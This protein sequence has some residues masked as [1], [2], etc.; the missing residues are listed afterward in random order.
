MSLMVRGK[1]NFDLNAILKYLWLF[2]L[3]LY[4]LVAL[5]FVS[6]N[7]TLHHYRQAQTAMTALYLPQSG[8]RLDYLTPI[9]GFPWKVP[10]EFP[11]FQWIAVLLQEMTNSDLI[12]CG[13]VINIFCHITT[14]IIILQIFRNRQLPISIPYTALI[15]YNFFPFYLVFDS[16]FLID[17]FSL[18]L[19]FVTVYFGSLFFKPKSNV[20]FLLLFLVSAICTGVSKSTTFIGVLAPLMAM[21]MMQELIRNGGFKKVGLV[22]GTSKKIV[23][24]GLSILVA[25]AVMYAWVVFSD[26]VK[27]DNPLAAEWT[28]SRTTAWNFGTIEQRLSFSNWKQYMSYSMLAHPL[29][30]I[31]L[32]FLMALFL[33]VSSKKQRVLMVCFAGLF[34]IPLLFFFNLFIIHTYYS[35]ANILFLYLTIAVLITAI[36]ESNRQNIKYAGCVTG[37]LI[38][39]FGSYRSYAF[40]HQITK[41]VNE[42]GVYGQLNKI[43]FNPDMNDVVVLIQSSRDPFLQYYF[44]CRGINLNSEEYRLYGEKDKL[45]QLSGGLKIKM[46]CIVDDKQL[47]VLPAE[48]A[49]ILPGEMKHISLS[50]QPEAN[51]YYNF[52]WYQ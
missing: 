27:M 16:V 30:Y 1:N 25:F 28:S 6:P 39:L 36:L 21:M 43:Q 29:F 24:I 7:F 42:P 48:Y 2:S 49:G 47:N 40:R 20:L 50:H 3:L 15:F 34:L 33:F 5:Y 14:N 19:A 37:V 17:T 51:K 11:L 23:A 22:S 18:T 52:F 26:T 13:K 35:V 46:I 31:A 10:L 9:M 12:V 32:T 8:F 38:L 45:K 44:K 41:S 4:S